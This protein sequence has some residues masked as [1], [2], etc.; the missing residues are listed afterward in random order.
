MIMVLAEPLVYAIVGTGYTD[1]PFFLTLYSIIFLYAGLGNLSVG[2][3]LNG[4]NKTQM[5]MKLALLRLGTGILMGLIF[6]PQFKVLGLILTTIITVGPSLFWG[7]W[8]IKKNFGA[9]IDW[10]ASAKI[11]LASLI[12]ALVTHLLLS[13]IDFVYF[14]ELIIGVVVFLLVYLV[15]APMIRAVNKKDV[16]SLREMLSGL[17]PLS[18][19]FNIPL[20]IIEKLTEIFSS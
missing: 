8:Y 1:A 16:N 6:I 7:L 5:S 19:I 14:I 20:I 17:G 9:T 4:Q 11:L 10:L 15:A 3:V 18:P 2:N 12:A 13:H